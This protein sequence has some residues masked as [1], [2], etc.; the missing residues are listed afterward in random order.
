MKNR[1]TMLLVGIGVAY[2]LYRLY[3]KKS[4]APVNTT[5]SAVPNILNNPDNHNIVT[6]KPF[7]PYLV[8]SINTPEL[9]DM[10]ASYQTYY[11]NTNVR[12]NGT[13]SRVPSTC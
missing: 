11:G 7:N 8:D 5:A 2:L 1:S 13:I 3:A 6:A 12:I 4:T 9:V 10:P